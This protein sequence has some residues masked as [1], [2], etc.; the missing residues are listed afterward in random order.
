[1]KSENKV[2]NIVMKK[3]IFFGLII[4]LISTISVSSFFAG[5]LATNLDFDENSQFIPDIND[6]QFE[7]ETEKNPVI[8]EVNGQEIRQ[9]EV[10]DVITSGFSQGQMLDATSALDMIITKI[11]LL[12]EA[13][14]R[15]ITITMNDAEEKLTSSYVQNG[16]SKEQFEEKLIE[17]GTTYDETLERFTDELTI[18]EMLTNEISNLDIQVSDEEAKTFFEDNRNVIQTQFGN[19]TV[20][21]DVSSQITENLLQQKRQQIVLDFV[22]DLRSNAMIMIYQD[23]LQ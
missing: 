20:Y 15:N 1:M 16:F 2:N 11:L 5:T 21:D 13:Q 14:N 23:K 12:D 3:S 8:A 4:L 9:E 17:L 19:S 7:T 6:I 22:E 18:N 10:N